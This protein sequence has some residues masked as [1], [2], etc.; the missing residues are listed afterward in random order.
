M[1]VTP[2]IHSNNRLIGLLVK[3]QHVFRAAEDIRRSADEVR[4]ELSKINN[5]IHEN[6][7]SFQKNKRNNANNSYGFE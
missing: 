5:D 3:R 2:Q 7:K 6:A 1:R 4:L